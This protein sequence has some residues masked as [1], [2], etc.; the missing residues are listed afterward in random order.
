MGGTHYVLVYLYELY[1]LGGK[2]Q[3]VIL[4]LYNSH[5]A[6]L[7]NSSSAKHYCHNCN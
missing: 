7:L 1:F 2:G 5:L 6:S 3:S 4:L